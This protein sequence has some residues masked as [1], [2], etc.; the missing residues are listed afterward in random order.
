[1]PATQ[2]KRCVLTL[3][4]FV[5]ET[6]LL[7]QALGRAGCAN[8]TGIVEVRRASRSRRQFSSLTHHQPAQCA[9]PNAH[10]YRFDSRLRLDEAQSAWQSISLNNTVWQSTQLRN[11]AEVPFVFDVDLESLIFVCVCR[12]LPWW[13]IV[14]PTPSS[15]RTRRRRRPSGRNSIASSIASPQSSLAFNFVTLLLKLVRC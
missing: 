9:A 2:A 13:S 10:I 3:T 4:C 12:R 11:A 7:L 8:F 14:A 5:F 15:T 6:I 1:M